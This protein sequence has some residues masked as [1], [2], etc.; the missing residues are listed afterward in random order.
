MSEVTE[1][2]E[3]EKKPK[4]AFLRFLEKKGVTLSPKLYFVDAMSAMAMGLFASLL[5][6][7][8]FGTV[9]KYIPDG[10]VF[11]D[12]FKLLA[13]I[14]NVVRRIS[15]KKVCL[16]PPPHTVVRSRKTY[17]LH[18]QLN[19]G[20]DETHRRVYGGKPRA[21]CRHSR[22]LR[23]RAALRQTRPGRALHACTHQ[24]GF[25]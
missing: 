8:I 2:K 21:S 1:N 20:P 17:S 22:H 12:F 5:M 4:C 7:T 19:A 14:G 25:P 16:Y 6:G 15:E 10:N 18:K 23:L 24:P 13:G 3:I 9:E 11:D